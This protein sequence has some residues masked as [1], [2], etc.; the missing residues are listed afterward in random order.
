ML[1]DFRSRKKCAR[2]HRMRCT[3]TYDVG[4]TLGRVCAACGTEVVRVRHRFRLLMR[5][6]GV[7]KIIL[8][9]DHFYNKIIA[10]FYAILRIYAPSLEGSRDAFRH[11]LIVFQSSKLAEKGSKST[12]SFVES[13]PKCAE[14]VPKICVAAFFSA[15]GKGGNQNGA[16]RPKV[17]LHSKNKSKA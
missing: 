17:H 8:C 16:R 10:C 12:H 9:A 11:E 4:V 7:T 6:G 15:K 5:T 13:V 1:F 2:L 14:S 3:K